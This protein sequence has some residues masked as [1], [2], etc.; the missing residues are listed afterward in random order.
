MEVNESFDLIDYL[1]G[2]DTSQT[3]LETDFDLSYLETGTPTTHCPSKSLESMLASPGSTSSGT[4][5]DG[6]SSL[7]SVPTDGLLCPVCFSIPGRHYHYGAKVCVS[8]KG[9]F[10]RAVQGRKAATF[11]CQ[12]G[13]RNCSI[14]SI[15]KKS[16]K[17][18]RFQKCLAA[19]MK[20]S[21]VRT[22]A[23]W[24]S[25][26]SNSDTDEN[27]SLKPKRKLDNKHTKSLVKQASLLTAFTEDETKTFKKLLT[28]NMQV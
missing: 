14:D 24:R 23:H 13:F 22:P 17:H 19:G 12:T 21:L 5:G 7:E 11:R 8:C 10:Q 20:P 3:G 27:G 6:A 2:K 28:D 9:F 18:C 26:T 15:S 4:S 25:T 16:C 1:V